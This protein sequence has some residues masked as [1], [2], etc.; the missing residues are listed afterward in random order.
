MKPENT[1]KLV[2]THKVLHEEFS[3]MQAISETM[4]NT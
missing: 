3:T 2:E 4:R 1:A